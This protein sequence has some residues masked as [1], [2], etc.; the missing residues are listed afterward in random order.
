MSGCLREAKSGSLVPLASGTV[1]TG[2]CPLLI[3]EDASHLT[4]WFQVSDIHW[5]AV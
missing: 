1:H 2:Y 3:E 5:A 4:S